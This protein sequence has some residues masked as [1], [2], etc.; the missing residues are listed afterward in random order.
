MPL[1]F[2]RRSAIEPALMLLP[3][4]MTSP[5]A[6]LMLL[7]IGLQES[8]FVHRR[9]IKGPARSFWQAEQGGG[10]V[11]GVLQHPLTKAH[12]LAVCAARDVTPDD[13]SVYAA[14]EHDDVLAA[15]L[16]RLLLW[17]DPARLP[18]L[19]DADGA[20]DLYLRQWRPGKPHRSTWNALYAQALAAITAPALTCSA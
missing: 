9:Q 16:A 4:K 20:W 7:C 12:A 19:G 5:Q 3:A 18:A 17:T 1:S 14:I 10:M 2:I 13:A 15:A 8:H 11:N 6:E